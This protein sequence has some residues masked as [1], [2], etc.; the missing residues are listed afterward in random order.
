VWTN[1]ILAGSQSRFHCNTA[2]LEP[3]RRVK[4]GLVDTLVMH[5]IDIGAQLIDTGSQLI[6]TD[7]Q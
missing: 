7:A 5:R 3:N 1:N 4:I 2:E 6:H